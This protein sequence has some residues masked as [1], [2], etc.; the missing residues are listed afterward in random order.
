MLRRFLTPLHPDGFK[1]VLA[2]AVVTLLLF[3]FWV[4]GGWAAAIVTLWLAYFFRDPWRVTPIRPGLLVSPADGS[5]VSLAAAATAPPELAMIGNG[6]LYGGQFTLFPQ[7]DLRDGLLEVCV[8]P[9][10]NWLTLVRCT[11]ALLLRRTLPASVTK[12]FQAP[13]LTLTSP[14]AA[15]LQIDG[16]I[17]HQNVARPKRLSGTSVHAAKLAGSAEGV[18]ASSIPCGSRARNHQCH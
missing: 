16:V 3:L 11:P 1:F 7:A 18:D 14:T 9:R 5:V 15:P 2:G 10:A 17:L 13:S 4:R 8:L 6:R 12:I